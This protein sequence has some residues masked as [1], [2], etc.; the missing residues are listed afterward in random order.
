MNEL[1]LNKGRA[2]T[3]EDER[4]LK[5]T[6]EDG[7]G[8]I[9]NSLMED[10]GTWDKSGDI[11]VDKIKINRNPN[12]EDIDYSRIKTTLG[13]ISQMEYVMCENQCKNTDTAIK[14]ITNMR[15]SNSDELYNILNS[16]YLK[17]KRRTHYLPTHENEI[18]DDYEKRYY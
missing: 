16:E 7:I 10:D 12:W 2:I 18:E 9:D 15:N 11:K 5:R 8:H 3:P 6:I 17:D 4:R 1:G 14:A 13:D